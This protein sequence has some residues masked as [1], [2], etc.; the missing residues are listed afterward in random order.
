LAQI[1]HARTASFSTAKSISN[2]QR[3]NYTIRS[4][5]R[6]FERARYCCIMSIS[7]FSPTEELERIAA[8]HARTCPDDGHSHFVGGLGRSGSNPLSYLLF[9][10]HCRALILLGYRDTM[11]RKDDLLAF[12]GIPPETDQPAGAI[13]CRNP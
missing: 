5:Q 11:E 12:L 10:N 9:E 8:R 1:R 2:L 13:P 3:I 6:R 4:F 7:A